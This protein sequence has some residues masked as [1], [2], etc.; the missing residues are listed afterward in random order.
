MKAFAALAIL[1]AAGS[2][3]AERLHTGGIPLTA[4]NAMI[5]AN[6]AAGFGNKAQQQVVGTQNP[7]GSPGR[8]GGHPLVSTNTLVGTNV[9]AGL[10][11]QAQQ[12]MTGLQGGGP[13]VDLDFS[14]KGPMVKTNVVV[15]TN[16]AA[17]IN[18]QA[19]Q[20]LLAQ[21]R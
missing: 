3:H 19:A 12:S 11:N 8:P 6:I 2:A 10:N 16:V 14:G 21:Q 7:G 4:N 5:G 17:G 1:L 15:G 20:G 9:A 13:M 18:N